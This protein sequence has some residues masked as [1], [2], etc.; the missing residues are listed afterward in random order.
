MNKL[1]LGENGGAKKLNGKNQDA[2]K[3]IYILEWKTAR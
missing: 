1:K 2:T 3:L